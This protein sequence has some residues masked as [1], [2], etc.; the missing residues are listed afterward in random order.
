VCE[1]PL[2]A[3]SR[4]HRHSS[5]AIAEFQRREKREKRRSERATPLE[6]IHYYLA[7]PWRGGALILGNEREERGREVG[8]V[9]AAGSEC[10]GDE[11]VV[12]LKL[13]AQKRRGKRISTG[14]TSCSGRRGR[15]GSFRFLPSVQHEAMNSGDADIGKKKEREKR[16]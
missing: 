7:H 13:R 3:E 8:T 5:A 4:P 1:F 6:L 2:D 12:P 14:R 15:G 11:P 16:K 9:K 10:D